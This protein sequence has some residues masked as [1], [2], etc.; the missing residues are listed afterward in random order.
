MN[1][2]T[3][4]KALA[5]CTALSIGFGTGYGLGLK[6]LDKNCIYYNQH[7]TSQNSID[8]ILK[9]T[10]QVVCK[11][12]YEFELINPQTRQISKEQIEFYGSGSGIVVYSNLE[13]RNVFMLTCDHVVEPPKEM[14]V[15]GFSLNGRSENGRY[16]GSYQR[17]NG[18][19]FN[20]FTLKDLNKYMNL[21]NK[22]SLVKKEIGVVI[23]EVLEGY[24]VK[25]FE[26][27]PMRE[28]A[29][30]G[31]DIDS[32][33]WIKNDDIALL[34][35][36]ENYRTKKRYIDHLARYP[37]WNSNWLKYNNLK[38]GQKI[39]VVGFPLGFSRQVSSGE[40]S[41]IIG[42]R[43]ENPDNFFFGTAPVSPGNSGGPVFV[44]TK[45]VFEGDNIVQYYSFAGLSRLGVTS[46]ENMN[47]FVHPRLIQEFLRKE[48]Y[49]YIYIPHLE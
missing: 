41:S 14:M 10:H 9:A 18:A 43:K 48:G 23:S 19:Q 37:A 29:H 46:G 42:I 33:D 11:A 8:D 13:E 24:D 35:F 25:D 39:A 5:L 40:I 47:G 7:S 31:I 15:F 3:P 22:A 36:D 32:K 6:K 20:F 21:F 45:E 49:S 30:T 16:F 27:F 34:K 1:K 28:I 44:A 4:K 26:L 12:T 38:E 2:K 17:D